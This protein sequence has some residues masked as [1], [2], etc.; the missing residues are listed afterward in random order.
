[1][2]TPHTRARVHLTDG[3]VT[4]EISGIL[5]IARGS[6]AIGGSARKIPIA[7]KILR[8]REL[9]VRTHINPCLCCSRLTVRKHA[10]GAQKAQTTKPCVSCIGI[11]TTYI[12]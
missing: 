3:I 8:I 11:Y 5:W 9:C 12:C 6:D 2:G 1:M 4:E 10:V 7:P